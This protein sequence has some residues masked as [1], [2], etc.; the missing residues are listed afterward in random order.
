MH[1]RGSGK[2]KKTLFVLLMTIGFINSSHASQLYVET[3]VLVMIFGGKALNIKRSSTFLENL[4]VGVGVMQIDIP[5]DMFDD[6]PNAV[7][8]GWEVDVRGGRLFFD[9]HITN[10]D[11]GFFIGFHLTYEKYLLQRSGASSTVWQLGEA[12]RFGYVWHPLD[13][14]GYIMPIL[15]LLNSHRVS[16]KN[17]VQ[18]ETFDPDYFG[19]QP[20]IG[21]GYS[22]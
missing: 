4:T 7:D 10:P 13:G 5:E 3:E 16:G 6:Y 2:M 20:S 14:G 15:T 12:L 19:F 17:E 8:K 21:L 22:F 11:K 9:Y 18:G 1:Y